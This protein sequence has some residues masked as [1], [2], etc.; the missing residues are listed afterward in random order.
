MSTHDPW[1]S[2]QSALSVF[3]PAG[4]NPL[5]IASLVLT[6][7]HVLPIEATELCFNPLIIASLV[8]TNGKVTVE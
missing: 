4:C 1:R 7:M 2:V 5:I 6:K 3:Y 8:L